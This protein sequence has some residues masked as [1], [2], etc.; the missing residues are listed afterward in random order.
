MTEAPRPSHWSRPMQVGDVISLDRE[1]FIG[2]FYK[3]VDIDRI[4]GVGVEAYFDR[5]CK[6]RRP[7][8]D[9]RLIPPKETV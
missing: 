7:M 9:G 2:I 3:I 1:P 4:I 8:A 5:A 6:F